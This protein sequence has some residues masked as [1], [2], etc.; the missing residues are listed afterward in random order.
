MRAIFAPVFIIVAT[1]GMLALTAL[2]TRYR[3]FALAA[4]LIFAFAFIM[5]APITANVGVRTLESIE[6][7]QC[8]DAPDGSIFIVLMGGASGAAYSAEDV[9]ILQEASMRR[10][11]LAVQFASPVRDSRLLISGGRTAGSVSEAQLGAAFVRR[12]S[13]PEDRIDIEDRS[14]DTLGSGKQ[15]ALALKARSDQRPLVLVT[16]ALHMPRA[17]LVFRRAGLSMRTCPVD[18]VYVRPEFP[19]GLLPQITALR[20]SSDVWRESA[21]LLVYAVVTRFRDTGGGGR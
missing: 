5:A 6:P 15:V 4:W 20:K 9:W 21:G 19:G 16:S 1:I 13:W 11:L 3:R 10:L 18:S 17:A 14:V 2:L 7:N 12:L 8:R